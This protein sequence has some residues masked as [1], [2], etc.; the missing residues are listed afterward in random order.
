M[1]VAENGRFNS[2]DPCGSRPGVGLQV[3][4]EN[5]FQLT[6]PVRV[7][8]S[9]ASSIQ[10]ES[11][12]FQLTRPVRVATSGGG[13]HARGADVSTHATRAG[14]DPSREVVCELV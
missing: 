1:Q 6:R 12:E 10:G 9:H 2:R 11:I 5:P 13:R 8:T 4:S 3:M 14:R 7:A